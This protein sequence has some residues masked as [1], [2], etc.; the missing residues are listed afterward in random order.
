MIVLDLDLVT[1]CIICARQI[2]SGNLTKWLNLNVSK[3]P[4]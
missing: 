4:C 3:L 1:I 2:K